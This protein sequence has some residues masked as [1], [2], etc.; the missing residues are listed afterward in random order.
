MQPSTPASAEVPQNLYPSIV[1]LCCP[2]Y[3]LQSSCTSD[4]A[5]VTQ[6]FLLVSHTRGLEL[7]EEH[8]YRLLPKLF[9]SFFT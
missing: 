3:A 9:I 1:S 7:K 2:A 5:E 4:L 8:I 6:L